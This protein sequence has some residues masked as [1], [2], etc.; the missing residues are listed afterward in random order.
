MSRS[1]IGT[2]PSCMSFGWTN[3]ISSMRSSFF[4]RT[5]QTR[6]SK[7]LLVTSRYFFSMV[8]ELRE[9]GEDTQDRGAREA[10]LLV[11]VPVL[12]AGPHLALDHRDRE[13]E[14]RREAA[15]FGRD[16]REIEQLGEL[17]IAV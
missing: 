13:G 6:P 4:R 15:V 5:A 16:T 7:S 8:H 11:V 3:L 10:R 9:R 14:L 1:V 12:P 17:L 2:L